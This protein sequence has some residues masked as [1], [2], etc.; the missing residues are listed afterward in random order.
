MS[1]NYITSIEQLYNN[2]R[3][4]IHLYTKFPGMLIKSKLG[5]CCG[6]DCMFLNNE[7]YIYIYRGYY[8]IINQYCVCC[9]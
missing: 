5:W 6:S 2:C 4:N 3:I 8:K 7:Y 1:N 9:F